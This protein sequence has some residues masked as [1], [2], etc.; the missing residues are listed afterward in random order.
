MINKQK[1]SR[2]KKEMCEEF[3]KEWK[4]AVKIIN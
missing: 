3:K 1:A 4:K 2:F